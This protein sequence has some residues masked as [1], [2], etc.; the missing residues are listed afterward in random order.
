MRDE[1][2]DT[3]VYA[4]HSEAATA[5]ERLQPNERTSVAN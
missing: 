5:S 1:S 4:S 2:A 3:H